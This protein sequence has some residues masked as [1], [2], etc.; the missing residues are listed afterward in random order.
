MLYFAM[1]PGFNPQR[2]QLFFFP[3]FSRFSLI[4]LKVLVYILL[5]ALRVI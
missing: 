3:F 5:Q 4:P 2:R 1:G